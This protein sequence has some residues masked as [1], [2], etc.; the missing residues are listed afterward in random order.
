MKDG[1]LWDR[2]HALF[3]IGNWHEGL[4]VPFWKYRAL[5][6]H[7]VKLKRVKQRV[8]CAELA[9]AADYCKTHGIDVRDVS[10]LYQHLG[11]AGAWHRERQRALATAD[12]DE[13]IAEAVAIEVTQP[14]SPWIDRLIRARGH[15]RIE[16]YASWKTWHQSS[17]F[18]G[19]G[20]AS[21]V[22]T[23]RSE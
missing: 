21:S 9:V 5:E 4:G 17:G 19:L 20:P 14:G 13:L 18:A 22:P 2:V 10:W 7:K 6:I 16:V 23:R 12:I 15:H 3:G 1:E 8:S 11:D